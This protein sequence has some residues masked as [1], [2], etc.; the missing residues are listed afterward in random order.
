MSGSSTLTRVD[1][2][3]APISKYPPSTTNPLESYTLPRRPWRR[4]TTP[5][6]RI[7]HHKYPGEG[8]V[9]SPYIVDWLPH[10]PEDP[11]RWSGT[12]K[13]FLIAV[14]AISTLCVA[15]SSSAYSGGI[16][17]MEEDFGASA[18]LLVGGESFLA[19]CIAAV[20]ATTP[21]ADTIPFLSPS[22]AQC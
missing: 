3:S 14:A 16:E 1:S 7:L 18:E 21:M 22:F 5:F 9:E 11:Q 4:Y 20:A 13:W 15:L 12:Y 2:Q 8:T 10:D 6:E 17:Y 19:I